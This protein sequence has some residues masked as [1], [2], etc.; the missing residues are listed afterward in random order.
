MTYTENNKHQLDFLNKTID[1]LRAL[2]VDP[3]KP[4]QFVVCGDQSSGTTPVLQALG[5]I[6]FPENPR[7][8]IELVQ[9]WSSNAS[10]EASIVPGPSRS[11]EEST[12]LRAF[13]AGECW[14]N[15]PRLIE[16]AK[17]YIGTTDRVSDD[18]LKIEISAPGQPGWAVVALPSLPHSAEDQD[19]KPTTDLVERYME[20][21]QSV[22]V[23]VKDAA[24]N[25]R[26]SPILRLAAKFDPHRR[27]TLGIITQSDL[28]KGE[29]EEEA[30]CIQ[31]LKNEKVH[32]KLGWLALAHRGQ[33]SQTQELA[34]QALDEKE[35]AFFS[36]EPWASLPR[37]SVGI[38]SL[39]RRANKIMLA[40][41]RSNISTLVGETNEEIH[42]LNGKL[43]KLGL[44]RS[45]IQQQKGYLLS[46]SSGF[47][48]I[49]NQALAGMYSDDFFR[50]T[51]EPAKLYDFRRL[52]AIVWQLNEYFADAMLTRGSRRRI[53]ETKP[54]LGVQSESKNPYTQ[55]PA[56]I[57]LLRSDLKTEVKGKMRQSRGTELVGTANQFIIGDLFQDQAQPWEGLAKTHMLRVW[58][59]VR[60]FISLALQHLADSHTYTLIIRT[61]VAPELAALKEKLLEKLD[62][63]T[64]HLKRSPPLPLGKAFLIKTQQARSDRACASV[65]ASLATTNDHATALTYGYSTESIRQAV[66]TLEAS[67]D[68]PDF[69]A[70]AIID[71]MEAYYESTLMIFV[72]NVAVL[73]IENCLLEPLERILTCQTI[74]NLEGDQVQ[75]IAEEPVHLSAERDRLSKDIEKLQAGLDV[76]NFSEPMEP[77]WANTT[78]F[79][80][81]H[82]PSEDVTKVNGN[83]TG[84][85]PEPGTTVPVP[86]PQNTLNNTPTPL[87][88][89]LY[90]TGAAPHDA[91][92]GAAV[93]RTLLTDLSKPVIGAPAKP[94]TA[95]GTGTSNWKSA[96]N[97]PSASTDL[98]KPLFGTP[99]NT[100]TGAA[101]D[102]LNT[103]KPSASTERPIPLFG[104]PSKYA[105]GTLYSDPNTT[106]PTLFG[107]PF[108]TVPEKDF[109]S[110]EVKPDPFTG[111][112]STKGY[113]RWGPIPAP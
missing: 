24:S 81:D 82:R 108:S 57:D 68:D 18:V 3:L 34:D 109:P 64:A 28:L 103:A 4:L 96:L 70:G 1:E 7:F 44:P 83:A 37:D 104:S 101:N 105:N 79:E 99:L 111:F 51:N 40:Y 113:D 67:R 32:L 38:D 20:D 31:T 65:G 25:H 2:G 35:K 61:I 58:E 80:T 91:L 88:P 97:G 19:F 93:P 63:L 8:P 42:S 30:A 46:I 60:Y 75:R 16:K 45:T 85:K 12:R 78:V 73:G 112:P 69:V 59:A 36:H 77:S 50:A 54:A 102:N 89:P 92:K 27:R 6:C 100:T 23:V 95:P 29:S 56:P 98:P 11:A 72:N 90:T 62:E 41:L 55:G 22:I 39:R 52:R 26:E 21:S 43:S 76:L 94:V 13:T 9:R 5:G 110:K 71:Q 53:I 87:V 84:K 49:V 66:S 14:S 33:S 47:E 86:K 10:V 74:N 15:V 107:V 17:E 48:R 106:R